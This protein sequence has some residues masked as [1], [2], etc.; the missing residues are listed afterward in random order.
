MIGRRKGRCRT[1]VVP[2]LVASAHKLSQSIF[3]KLI[4]ELGDCLLVS[5]DDSLTTQSVFQLLRTRNVESAGASNRR[6]CTTIFISRKNTD[7]TASAARE[8]YNVVGDRVERPLSWND[9]A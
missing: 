8:S 3:S 9:C 7:L 6:Q 1:K 4:H 5:C 2:V